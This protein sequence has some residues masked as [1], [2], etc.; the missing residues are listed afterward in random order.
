MSFEWEATFQ[1]LLKRSKASSLLKTI[2]DAMLVE[3][4]ADVAAYSVDDVIVHGGLVVL[5]TELDGIVSGR[6]RQFRR[7]ILRDGLGKRGMEGQTG[8]AG[9]SVGAGQKDQRDGP[10]GGS[11]EGPS[12]GDG[13]TNKWRAIWARDND[14]VLFEVHRGTSKVGVNL[15]ERTC[16]CNAWQLTVMYKIGLKPEEHVH[17][18]LTMQSIRATYIHCI[19]PVDSEEY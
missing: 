19:K 18:W 3:E 11:A 4:S 17:K 9:S 13:P 1:L 6:C 15:Q 10:V 14:R 8:E 2:V 12:M 16:T 7:H 5:L